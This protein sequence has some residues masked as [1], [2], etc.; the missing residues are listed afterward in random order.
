MPRTVPKEN[1]TKPFPSA[2]SAPPPL[3]SAARDFGKELVNWLFPA[4][5]TLIVASIF[6]FLLKSSMTQGHEM[7]LDR[8][9]LTAV[10]AVT[11][12]GFPQAAGVNQL[13]T[14]GQILILLL[15]IAGSLFS[16]IT[17]GLAVR[18]ILRL[19]Y[20]DGQIVRAALLCEVAALVI[21]VA[22]G[23]GMGSGFVS[24]LSQGAAVLGN[25]GVML[26]KPFG[27]GAW[28]T[29]MIVVPMLFFGAI[30]IT[31]LMELFDLCVHGRPISRHA[32][33]ALMLSLALYVVGVI[34][35][36]LLQCL[37]VDFTMTSTK[38]A[39]IAASSSVA[40]INSRTGGIRFEDAYLYPRAMQWLLIVFMLIGASPGGTGGGMK[41]TTFYVL[42]GGTRRL[43]AGQNPGRGFGIAMSW[44]GMYLGMALGGLV[45]LLMAE[46]Q[47]GA[48]RV[49]FL[50][51]SALG[52]V[53]L[54]HD[55]LSNS[56]RGTYVLAALMLA[57]RMVPPLIL[58]WMADTTVDADV[59]VG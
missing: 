6:V 20:G 40:A 5:V 13:Q 29:Q 51:A 28:Q 31:V 58:W 25:S 49:A 1:R 32:R 41:A 21:G 56:P 3:L 34:L 48:D 52:N 19:P 54:A 44:V 42:F 46:P 36:V 9:V 35:F 23:C 18:R 2:S 14:Q 17:G 43:L 30:G 7:S 37:A 38:F 8:A 39:G 12:T 10:N 55:T 59:A 22:G 4:Y 33:V 53:G 57:G 45:L 47:M 27:I 24:G 11:L 50:A 15:T 16:F 26:G